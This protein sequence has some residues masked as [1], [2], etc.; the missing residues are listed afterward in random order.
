[1]REVGMKEARS[2]WSAILA[3]AA[4]GEEI[5]ITRRGKPIARLVM[6]IQSDSL[7]LK[8]KSGIETSKPRP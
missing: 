5:T 6:P 3:L 1:M 2:S 7:D 8:R 4:K